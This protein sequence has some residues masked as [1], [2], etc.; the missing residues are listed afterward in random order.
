MTDIID[1]QDFIQPARIRK[2]PISL[3][4]SEI[5][6]KITAAL[7]RGEDIDTDTLRANIAVL[8]EGITYTD[9]ELYEDKIK[10]TETVKNIYLDLI[11]MLRECRSTKIGLETFNLFTNKYNVDPMVIE[12]NTKDIREITAD[13]SKANMLDVVLT[14]VTVTLFTGVAAYTALQ[15]LVPVFLPTIDISYIPYIVAGIC[16]FSAGIQATGFC[17]KDLEQLRQYKS[18]IREIKARR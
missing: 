16:L 17:S 4:A 5:I 9:L 14:T 7:D 8:T 2:Q 10:D 6:T 12:D 15:Y 13:V 3:Y 11:E 1:N 18:Y